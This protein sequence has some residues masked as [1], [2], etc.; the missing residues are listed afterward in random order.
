[1]SCFFDDTMQGLL[2]AV[3]IEKGNVPL[4]KRGGTAASAYY[5]PN[6]E[7]LVNQFIDI[8]KSKMCEQES[9]I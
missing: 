6:G 5:I 8:R 1:M 3:E 9:R 7:K 4:V 2:Q